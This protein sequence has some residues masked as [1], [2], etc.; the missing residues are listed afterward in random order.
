MAEH[1]ICHKCFHSCVCDE[2]L[3]HRTSYNKRCHYFVDYFVDV[4]SVSEIKRGRWK[5]AGMGDF[6]C[7]LCSEVVSGNKYSYCPHCGAKMDS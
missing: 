6:A 3:A 5:G 4:S 1:G 2:F 7:S